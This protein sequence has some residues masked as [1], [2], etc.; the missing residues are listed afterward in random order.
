MAQPNL[1]HQNTTQP[2]TTQPDT[3]HHLLSHLPI[4]LSLGSA[5]KLTFTSLLLRATSSSLSAD[6]H[7]QVT[8][9]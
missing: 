8:D 6:V 3:S 9:D 5:T 2:I 1:A 4:F 7:Y